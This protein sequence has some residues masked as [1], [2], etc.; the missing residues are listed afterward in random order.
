MIGLYLETNN[1]FQNSKISLANKYEVKEN[2]F[3]Y[4]SKKGKERKKNTKTASFQ[5]RCSEMKQKII[6]QWGTDMLMRG[7]VIEDSQLTKVY[8]SL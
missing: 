8:N 3:S 2:K 6:R 7:T 5:M 1:K 4:L